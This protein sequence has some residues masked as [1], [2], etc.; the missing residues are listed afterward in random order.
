MSLPNLPYFIGTFDTE[1]FRQWWRS[2]PLPD[3][4]VYVRKG[5]H[6]Y[7]R[8]HLAIAPRRDGLWGVYR[9]K[10][11]GIDWE[12]VFLTAETIYDIV[13][14]N[15]GWAIMNTSGGF[16][17]T[18]NAGT[19]WTKILDAPPAPRAPAFCN[20]GG[21]DVLICTDG[22]YI[23]RS[24]NIA[25]SWSQVCDQRSIK[26]HNGSFN[27]T[28]PSHP[29]VAGANDLAIC[30]FGPFMSISMDGGLTWNHHHWWDDYWKDPIYPIFPPASVVFDRQPAAANK[31]PTYIIKQLLISSITGPRPED[32]TFLLKY[33]DLTPIAGETKLYSRIFKTIPPWYPAAQVWRY[34][35]QQ[36]I[37]PA[38]GYQLDAYDLPITGAAGN[39]R[40]AFSA[41]TRIDPATGQQVPSLKYSHDGG[42]SW[43]DIDL[44]SINVGSPDGSPIYGGPSLDDSF[45]R[46][47]WVHGTCDNAGRWCFTDGTRRQ[48][49]SQEMDLCI[50]AK[51]S[52]ECDVDVVIVATGTKPQQLDAF[53]S[54][55]RDV[56]S[57]IDELIQGRNTKICLLDALVEGV[58]S[59]QYQCD[60]I[61]AD[62]LS[63]DYQMDIKLWGRFQRL[64]HLDALL[65]GK[66]GAP[67]N[68]DMVLIRY[69]LNKRLSDTENTIPQ[70]FDIDVPFIPSAPYNSRQE[71][72]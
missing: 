26:R 37:S 31:S 67:Y 13:I 71:T 58:S 47:V 59:R 55:R 27:Y 69:G 57:Q 64:Y 30:G 9:S 15:F 46:N 49:L 19:S 29:C 33:D 6:I 63:S 1:N 66:N 34:Q 17:E 51:A 45:A 3:D 5:L 44:N 7:G 68:I 10:N 36:Y 11:Y 54:N 21:G 48:N 43:I 32:V 28:G 25:R 60:A 50:M 61:T 41:Q 52:K 20:I 40:L 70:I 56:V 65:K 62:D 18:V 14:I 16:Y 38:D 23:W 72:L 8:T 39:D 35:F 22:R 24:T 2:K 4:I 53:F 42:I 12:R